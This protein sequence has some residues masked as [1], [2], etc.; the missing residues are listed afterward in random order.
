MDRCPFCGSEPLG[1][2]PSLPYYDCWMP[3][4]LG[5]EK[6]TWKCLNIQLA[7]QAKR[8]AE[9]EGL[10]NKFIEV[11]DAY[12]RLKAALAGGSHDR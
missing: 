7:T 2:D 4:D 5:R 12:D 6:R 8:L 11:F 10:I 3:K 1:A 9:A